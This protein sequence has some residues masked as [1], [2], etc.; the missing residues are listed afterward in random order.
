MPTETSNAFSLTLMHCHS[1][2]VHPIETETPLN[3]PYSHRLHVVT[4]VCVWYLTGCCLVGGLFCTG[5]LF[6]LR[7]ESLCFILMVSSGFSLHTKMQLNTN[8]YL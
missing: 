8:T 3:N 2:I 6:C 1:F 5:L 7:S 4:H